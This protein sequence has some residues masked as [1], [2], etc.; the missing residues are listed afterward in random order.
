MALAL[1]RH[2]QRREHVHVVTRQV[3]ADQALEQDRPARPGGRQEDQQTGRGAA[4]RDHVEHAAKLG[5]LLE[6]A[7]RVAVE[8]VEQAGYAVE[9]RAGARVQ[10]HVVERGSGEDNTGVA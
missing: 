2:G 10:G 5:G 7:R 3:Q 1:P 9:E 8:R 4:V 6:V